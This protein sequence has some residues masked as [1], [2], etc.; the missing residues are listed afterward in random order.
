ML[1]DSVLNE[2]TMSTSL[3]ADVTDD[4]CM[5]KYIEIV[6]LSRD[7]DV[8]STTECD[9]RDWSL[10]VSQEHL[11]VVKQELQD[12]CCVGFFANVNSFAIC[13]RL[14][15]CRMSVCNVRAPYSGD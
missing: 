8:P 11:P 5:F 4:S 1:T 3:S 6:P 7:T 9:G 2:E 14:S 15:V 12:V 10:Q 13:H